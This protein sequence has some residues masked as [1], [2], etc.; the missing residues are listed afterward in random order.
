MAGISEVAQIGGIVDGHSFVKLLRG[1]RDRSRMERPLFWHFPNNWGPKGPGIGAS[2]A[3]RLGD[4]KLIYYHESQQYELFNLAR[5]LEEQHNLADQQPQVRD[6]LAAELGR[7]LVSTAAQMPV[8]KAT[9]KA[10]PYPVG[11]N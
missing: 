10:V 2:S 6:R 11:V 5:D 3:V 4:W 7:Y 9:G 1:E 8:V